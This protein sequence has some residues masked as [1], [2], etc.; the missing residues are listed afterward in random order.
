MYD[1][2]ICSIIGLSNAFADNCDNLDRNKAW[3]STFDL[4][5]HAYESEDYAAALQYSRDLEN[6]CEHSPI[7]NYTIAYIY[8][9]LGDDEKY[10]FYLTKSTQ[11]TER[12]SVDKN[13]LDKIWTDK[14]IA[15]HPEAA[16]ENIVKLKSEN[17]TLKEQLKSVQ[18][19]GSEV[20]SLQEEVSAAHAADDALLWTSVAVSGAGIILTAVGAYTVADNKKDAIIGENHEF[21]VKS[22]YPLGWGLVAAGITATVVGI[23]G[24]GLFGYKYSKN[25]ADDNISDLS[26]SITP[27]YSSLSI[28]F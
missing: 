6:I 18:L 22:A 20:R 24:T 4:L 13:L 5:N 8:K 23:V 15:A 28:T 19:T 25:H 16:P 3:T 17:E 14:Y 9:K 10:L 12:F 2:G 26:I 27:T 1:D 11:N 7:L 21:K